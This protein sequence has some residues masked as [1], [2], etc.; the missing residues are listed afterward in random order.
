MSS[1]TQLGGSKP[2]CF[3][4]E[5]LQD[6]FI[7]KGCFNL[8]LAVESREKVQVPTGPEA[9]W[10]VSRAARDKDAEVSR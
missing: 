5:M 6:F 1:E 10:D 9:M 7:F 3:L 4:K 8:I 2:S